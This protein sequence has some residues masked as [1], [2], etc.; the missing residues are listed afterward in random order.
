MVREIKKKI[1]GID[2]SVY[3]IETEGRALRLCLCYDAELVSDGLLRG[4]L[5]SDR[6]EEI[7]CA[8]A[9]SFLPKPRV[10]ILCPHYSSPITLFCS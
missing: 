3:E 2:L 5:L 7:C 9:I 1:W 10:K 6:G 4:L 8:C